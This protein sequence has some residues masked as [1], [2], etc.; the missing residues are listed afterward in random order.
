MRKFIQH[1]LFYWLDVHQFPIM[2]NTMVDVKFFHISLKC[3]IHCISYA[4]PDDSP[5]KLPFCFSCK[6]KNKKSW[7]AQ[8]WIACPMESCV[9]LDAI[10]WLIDHNIKRGN[11][12][13]TAILLLR[14]VWTAQEKSPSRGLIEVLKKH[15]WQTLSLVLLYFFCTCILHLFCILCSNTYYK[16]GISE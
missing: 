6:H 4:L 11:T 5:R 9:P 16:I 13:V 7:I 14:T 2:V 3:K 8:S 10:S 12:T 15:M 1:Q